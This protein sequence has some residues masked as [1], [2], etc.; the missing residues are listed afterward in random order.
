MV[1]IKKK[2]K[3]TKL[4]KKREYSKLCAE[5]MNIGKFS[6]PS[7]VFFC[8]LKTAIQRKAGY[9]EFAGS[10]EVRTFMFSLLRDQV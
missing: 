3:N 2:K 1:H 6:V 9:C 8:K 5:E 7:A 4:K 10:P